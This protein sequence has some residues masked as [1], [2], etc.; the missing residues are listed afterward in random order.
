MLVTTRRRRVLGRFGAA[1]VGASALASALTGTPAN[2]AAG[3]ASVSRPSGTVS[4]AG[5]VPKGTYRLGNV[6]SRLCLAYDVERRGAARQAFCAND[7]TI[8][9][10]VVPV[11]RDN[12]E[13]INAHN[14]QCL[15]IAGSS[16]DDGAAAFVFTCGNT[17]DQHFTLVPVPAPPSFPQEIPGFEIVN[18]NSGKCVSVGGART[19]PE[20]WVIQWT[21]AGTGDQI[22]FETSPA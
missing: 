17:A 18:V 21:C 9:W 16:K 10:Q 22:W 7:Y 12:Y 5:A 11:S 1:L 8:N 19:E 3:T 15:S 2:A 4:P 20:A 6:N 13:L 14:G